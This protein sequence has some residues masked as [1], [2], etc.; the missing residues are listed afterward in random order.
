MIRIDSE[1]M[2]NL[3]VYYANVCGFFCVGFTLQ[4]LVFWLENACKVFNK[5]LDYSRH[6]KYINLFSL[7]EHSSHKM[8]KSHVTACAHKILQ[9]ISLT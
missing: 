9:T 4:L 7:Y 3:F 6:Q 1:F 2:Q 8:N 5:H